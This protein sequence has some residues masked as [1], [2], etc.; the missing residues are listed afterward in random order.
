LLFSFRV[1]A[2]CSSRSVSPHLA[3]LVPCFCTLLFSFR[4]SAPCY[5]RSVFPH[6][7][8]LVPWLRRG[9][10]GFSSLRTLFMRQSLTCSVTRQSLV[11]SDTAI[12]FLLISRLCTLLFSFRGSAA[13][14][15]ASLPCEPHS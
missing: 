4:V 8:L 14:C 10:L 5:S 1:S 2:P 12:L 9:M 7:V 13:E 3:I 15:D 6:I 11:T